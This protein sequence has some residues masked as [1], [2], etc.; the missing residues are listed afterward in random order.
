MTH[1]EY[2]NW[3]EFPSKY[4]IA[5]IADNL[6]GFLIVGLIAAAFV[7]PGEARSQAMPARAA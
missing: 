5:N 6:I 4:T 7:K 1:V 2:W 3:Y